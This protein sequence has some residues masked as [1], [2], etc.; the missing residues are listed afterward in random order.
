MPCVHV[1]ILWP[2]TTVDVLLHS[3]D[4]SRYSTSLQN[5]WLFSIPANQH[6][7]FNMHQ[8]QWI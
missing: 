5:H 4:R 3:L 8:Q 1:I 2:N 6:A 7:V